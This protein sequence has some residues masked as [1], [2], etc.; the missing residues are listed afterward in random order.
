[1]RAVLLVAALLCVAAAGPVYPPEVLKNMNLSADPCVDF[2]GACPCPMAQSELVA[3]AGVPFPTSSSPLRR[4]CRRP[5]CLSHCLMCVSLFPPP[6]PVAEYACGA[7]IASTVLGPTEDV[8][9]KSI[10][11]IQNNND[12]IIAGIL[13]NNSYPKVRQ[14]GGG[15]CVAV[16]WNGACAFAR[17]PAPPSV[18]ERAWVVVCESERDC[19]CSWGRAF[20]QGWL[21]MRVCV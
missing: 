2:Y 12:A 21:C 5:C 15:R 17:R 10:S 16:R 1:M 6:F 20:S 18:L 11:T 14:G 8:I 7:W 13:Q 3:G 9:F 19:V 4:S